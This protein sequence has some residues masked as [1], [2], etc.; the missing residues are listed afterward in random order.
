MKAW[1]KKQ[2]TAVLS[3]IKVPL[4]VDDVQMFVR[5]AKSKGL[6]FFSKTCVLTKGQN[7]SLV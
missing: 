1:L 4:S 3:S 7:G 2:T 5:V 6:L